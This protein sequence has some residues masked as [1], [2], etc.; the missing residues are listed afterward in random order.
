MREEMFPLGSNG[1][2]CNV[3]RRWEPILGYHLK[4][5]G[6]K[7]SGDIRLIGNC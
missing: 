2:S 5:E 4:I 7:N 3:I 1:L 6:K